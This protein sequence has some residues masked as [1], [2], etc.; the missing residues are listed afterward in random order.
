MTNM[1]SQSQPVLAETAIGNAVR[2]G[3]KASEILAAAADLIEPEGRWIKGDFARN[4]SGWAGWGDDEDVVCYC[5]RGAIQA[6]LADH[7]SAIEYAPL[8]YL[9]RAAGHS[10]IPTWNDAPER[11][12]AEVV[13]KLREAAALA[14]AEGQ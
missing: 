9:K 13:A 8:G 4:A 14:A 6:A 11:T 12:Q 1:T 2:P 10:V 3:K 7:G 5:A